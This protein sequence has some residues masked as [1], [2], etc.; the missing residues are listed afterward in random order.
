METQTH[1][2]R[3][4]EIFALLSQYLDFE[5][6]PDACREIEAHLAGC[7][8]C[9]EFAETLRQTVELCHRYNPA[10]M[11]PPLSESARDQLRQ[12]YEKMLWA[13]NRTPQKP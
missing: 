11:P 1:D 2:E 10:E 6:P 4:K 13:K 12:A 3:C 9:V 8:P 7:A 5:L